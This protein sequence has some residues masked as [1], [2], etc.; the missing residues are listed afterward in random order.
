MRSVTVLSFMR[1][2]GLGLEGRVHNAKTVWQNGEQL[3]QAGVIEALF[4]T[5]DSYLKDHRYLAIRVGQNHRRLD[6]GGTE[7]SATAA[8]RTCA[9]FRPSRRQAGR[10]KQAQR[11]SK[12]C[13]RSV[14]QEAR[15]EPLRLQ[16]P[17]QA[18]NVGTFLVHHNHV[19]DAA[20]HDSQ[21]LVRYPRLGT[22]RLWVC[23]RTALSAR[24]RCESSLKE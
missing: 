15:Q 17:C 13:R 21:N 16:K 4:E 9:Y 23:G 7:F 3:T 24:R 14:D 5:L 22:T 18:C 8:R 1:F 12:G 19:S 20:V 10:I 6:Y 2:L 11:H